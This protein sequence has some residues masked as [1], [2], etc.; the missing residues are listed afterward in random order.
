MPNNAESTQLRLSDLR[1]IFRLIGECTELRFDSVLWRRHMLIELARLTGTQ[2]AMGGLAGSAHGSLEPVLVPAVDIGW[3]GTSERERFVQFF[4]DKMY[5]EDPVLRAMG[6]QLCTASSPMSVATHSR[7]QLADDRTWYS[8][9]AFC[10][11]HRL[12]GV[13][14]GLLSIVPL[15]DGQLHIVCLHRPLGAKAFSAK[16]QQL[17]HVFH[18][19]LA[20]HLET[21]LAAPGDDPISS[22]SPRLRQVLAS[23]IEGD[24]EQQV[25]ARLGL[26]R[27]T[28]HQYIKTLY[29]QLGVCTR[30]ELM[31]RFIRFP[32]SSLLDS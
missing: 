18:A 25:A 12:S 17:L 2:V 27:G 32:L 8:S 26:T 7:R 29:R 1:A 31:A 24:S 20:A 11:Y 13:D 16:E 23:L 14:D 21:D 15:S 4:R 9:V 5:L 19:E 10:D 28:T 22:L 30:G 3:T 6:Q